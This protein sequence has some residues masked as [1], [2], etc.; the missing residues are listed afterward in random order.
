MALAPGK[1]GVLFAAERSAI[2]PVQPGPPLMTIYRYDLNTRKEEKIAERVS[3]YDVS[4]NGEKILVRQQQRWT[5]LPTMTPPKPGEGTLNLSALDVKVD[6]IAEWRQMYREVWRGE[7]DFFYSPQYHGLDIKA[8]EAR[9]RPY[10]DASGSRSD[11]MYV[12]GEMLGELTVS[13][14][15]IGGPPPPPSHVRGGLLG[16]DYAIANGRYRFAR[17][18]TG[19]SW[20]P[21]LRAPLAQPGAMV[22]AGEYLIAINGDDIRP[23]QD[24]DAR[25]E[26]KAGQ[27]VR[28]T[29]SA[30]PSG[31]NP[32]ELSVVQ[33]DDERALRNRAWV[34][35]NRRK[36]DQASGGTIAYVYL[37]NTT[38]DGYTSFNR[39]FFSQL[40]RQAVLVDERYNGG[41]A[42]ADYVV[43]YL[44]RPFLNFIHVR[45][46]EDDVMPFGAVFGPKVMVTNEF[47]G[48]GGDAVAYYFRKMGVGPIVGK[49]TWGGLVR[50]GGIPLL[51]DGTRV[52]APDAGIWAEDEWVAE[53]KGIA[54]DIEV[55]QDPALVRQGR[56]P[57]LERAIAYLLDEMKKTPALK[58]SHPPF[59]DYQKAKK[60]PSQQ[61]E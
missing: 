21:Q 2:N 27:S 61:F 51:M 41:G 28:I 45:H 30:D 22:A 59:S 55:D 35:D 31:A 53:N 13:H 40:N 24:I 58:K 42:L 10:L 23:P 47:A 8:A 49:R 14:M 54:P 56:D 50:N 52:S 29:V 25:L 60:S 33:T 18:L 4:H 7:R 1:P 6:P 15:F 39:Y 16:A 32:R 37:P 34:E 43:D 48:S 20:N 12:F 26:A 5:I 19:E 3:A 57:Q 44:R 38:F 17:V 46:G 36:V 11:V 9:Y